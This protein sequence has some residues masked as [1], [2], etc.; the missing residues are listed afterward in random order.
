MNWVG[1]RPRAAL[2]VVAL[3]TVTLVAVVAQP[4]QATLSS[5]TTGL[6]LDG[7]VGAFVGGGATR[8]F[9]N[10]SA[11]GNDTFVTFD[12][13]TSTDQFT[14]HFAP[15]AGAHL[16]V[17]TYE[18]A[19]RAG[20]QS[21][22]H[23]GI[24]VNGDGAGCNTETGRFIVDEVSF[25]N[26]GAPKTASIRFEQHCEGNDEAL[27][28]A[29]SY[30]ATAD[31]RTR[32]VS[33]SS[34]TMPSTRPGSTSAPRNETITNQG[35]STL[36]VSNATISG[37]NAQDF[38]I[39]SNNC[40]A[41]LS[42]GQSCTIGVTFSPS[43][44]G[45]R[46]AALTF[47]DQ[48]AP[49]GGG[50]TGRDIPLSGSNLGALAWSPLN[51]VVVSDPTSAVTASQSFLYALDTTNAMRV[52]TSNAGVWDSGISIPAAL[53]SVP[54]PT[55]TAAGI[56]VF[57]SGP[58]GGVEYT[59]Q[60]SNLQFTTFQTLGG[61][62]LS[63][64]AGESDASGVYVFGVGLDHALYFRR[65][66]GSTWSPWQS[67]GGYLTSDL[68]TAVDNTGLYVFGRGGDGSLWYRRFSGGVPSGWQSLGGFADSFPTAISTPQGI[69][70]FILG[71]DEA[72]WSRRVTGTPT[73]WT[74]LG[75]YFLS[76][77]AETSDSSGLYVFGVGGDHAMWSRRVSPAG[78]GWS[79][80]GGYFVSNPTA[81]T[82][83]GGGGIEVAGLGTDSR[84][85]IRSL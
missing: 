32:T 83:P 25:D 7:E 63:T 60:P 14:L 47:F 33:P 69:T 36:T 24:D 44:P 1:V 56:Y 16:A 84:M 78:P 15:V 54:S 43:G 46:N 76:A 64:P 39:A 18:N 48:L 73:G 30:N 11:A 37:A 71:G 23:P 59:K 9:T 61:K 38:H 5:P 65:L 80:L 82:D 52:W 4:A 8:T 50:G 21:A 19:Q 34:L 51:G 35:P 72:A 6:I 85:W 27:F 66:V 57:M 31:Y 74:S 2:A 58:D 42:Q 81:L 68:A 20:L 55:S 45:T 75:G 49:S 70:V 3:L 62:L 53:T 40:G 22:G 13:S 77:L 28:G 67:L 26:G 10:V 29:V 79:S 17:G 12:V 41:S